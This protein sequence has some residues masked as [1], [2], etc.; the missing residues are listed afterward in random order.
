MNGASLASETP[1]VHVVE[2]AHWID[3][4]SESM[5]A[6]FVTVIPRT[7]S[8]VLLT[9]RPEYRGALTRVAG[10]Q[11]IALAPLSDSEA[12]A[13]I[14]ELLGPDPSVGGLA[15]RIAERAAGN[16]F[17]AE[18]IVRELAERGV[19]RGQRGGYLSTADVAEVSVPATLQA[20]SRRAYRSARAGSKTH[21]ERGGG[22][23]VA[24][25][26]GD[27]LTQLGVE[28]VVADLTA[29]QF[30]DQVKFTRQ[31]EY[32]FH[33]PLIRAVAYE[34]QLKSD[35]AELHRRV[36]AAIELHV[37]NRSTRTPP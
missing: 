36:A 18:E 1:A 7:P 31:P 12:T 28:P 24:V 29:A 26:P 20:T 5:L 15:D 33:H 21:V 11:T 4:A 14:A 19:L 13:L 25:Q 9:Y 16:P 30:I 35:R 22:H 37:P 3:E 32:V 27:L 34:A 10:A 23:R 17:F 8:L 2:D 6:D